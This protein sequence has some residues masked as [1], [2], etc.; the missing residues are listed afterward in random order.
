M[1]GTRR[2]SCLVWAL[3]WTFL[4]CS[5]M[6]RVGEWPNSGVTV[7]S[8]VTEERP[9]PIWQALLRVSGLSSE[10]AEAQLP[11]ATEAFRVHRTPDT[12][13]WVLLLLLRAPPR[14]FG[15]AW[16]LEILGAAAQE[17]EVDE[18]RKSLE[19]LLAHVF[20]ER[21]ARQGALRR[22]EA[23]REKEREAVHALQA[24]LEAQ[25]AR[26][27]GLASERDDHAATAR[28]LQATL[29]E[30]RT[31]ASAL[32][33]QLDQLKAIEKILQRREGAAGGEGSP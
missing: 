1:S 17:E 2:W 12:R 7:H 5:G 16:A 26:A 33:S 22:A 21:L 18:H 30:E 14:E 13:L 25:Q 23:G 27:Q 11:E 20:S 10:A 19:I 4:G 15:D 3:A 9:D 32:E 6:G 29:E 28:S 31:R 24:A 8:V